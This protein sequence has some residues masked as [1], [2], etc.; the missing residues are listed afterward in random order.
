MDD[1]KRTRKKS[2]VMKH[3]YSML[4]A[5]FL[6]APAFGQETGNEGTS[7]PDTTQFNFG[8]HK[9]III[10]DEGK[11]KEE[12]DPEKEK[13]K[14]RRSPAH[15][16]GVEFGFNMLTDGDFGNSFN[17]NPYWKND[18]AKS[19]VWNLNALE[20]K[21]NFGTQ[22]V[23]LTTGLG[24]SWTSVAFSE[25]YTLTNNADTIFGTI[26]TV[27]IYTKNKLKAS[28]LTVP[29]LLE[30]NTKRVGKLKERFYLAGGV[31]GGV[32]LT[33]K[34]KRQGDNNGQEFKLKEKGT[35][36]LN[37]F[38][39]DATVRLGYGHWGMYASYSL[40][41]MF[42]TNKTV[43]VHPFNFGLSLNF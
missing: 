29:L 20:H 2:K 22:Y 35:Y 23:G 24:F 9:V 40:L 7:E 39:L 12:V 13:R 33:S 21:F 10:D 43:A 25:N 27:N 30:F 6:I 31:I 36:A 37:P 28:Y 19:Q 8:K 26:D 17:A 38:K 5:L 1:Q 34:M 15:W 11:V 4:A 18:P 32:R 3:L 41:P 16:A 42:D 14:K